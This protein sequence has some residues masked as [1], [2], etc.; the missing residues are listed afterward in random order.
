VLKGRELL[1]K[2]VTLVRVGV[3]IVLALAAVAAPAQESLDSIYRFR[4]LKIPV[5][6]KVKDAVIECGPCD[7][8]FLKAR[9]SGQLFLRLI[10]KGKVM[11][12]VAGRES[13]YAEG[14]AVPGKPTLKMAKDS[15]AGELILTFESGKDHR[16]FPSLRAKFPIPYIEAP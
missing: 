5:S 8:E 7:L 3:C 16:I 12:L 6:L 10:K 14:E 1:M 13:A 2:R 9:D 11:D 15:G 4:G